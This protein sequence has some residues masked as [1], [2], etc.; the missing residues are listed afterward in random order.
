MTNHRPFRFGVQTTGA[1]SLAKWRELNKS[2]EV[3]G[4]SVMLAP[5]HF[6]DQSAPLPALAVAA[7]ATTTL[8]W[9]SWSSLT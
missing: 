7:R 9:A 4:Y 6:D 5:D 1:T 8:R 3:A 2:I